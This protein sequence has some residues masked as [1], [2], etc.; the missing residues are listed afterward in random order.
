M[1]GIEDSA[2]HTIYVIEPDTSECNRLHSFLAS[3]STE[4]KTFVSAE[5]F[6]AQCIPLSRGCLVTE[7]DL[8]GMSVLELLDHLKRRGIEL[9]V[10]VLGEGHNMPLAVSVIRA[11][12]LEFIEKPFATSRL[13]RCVRRLIGSTP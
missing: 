4:V 3:T 2:R 12:A 6:L 13:Q 7:V 5:S 9:P 10:I 11:G 1:K 8:P